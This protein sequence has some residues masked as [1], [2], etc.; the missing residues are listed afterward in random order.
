MRSIF[1]A[2][3]VLFAVLFACSNAPPPTNPCG[4]SGGTT[5]CPPGNGSG[6]QP[7]SN[8]AAPATVGPTATPT[9][10]PVGAWAPVLSYDNGSTPPASGS[11]VAGGGTYVTTPGATDPYTNIIYMLSDQA[12]LNG[13]GY[14]DCHQNSST[15]AYGI[16][17]GPN[18]RP[19]PGYYGVINGITIPAP[20]TRTGTSTGY[21]SQTAVPD[22][23]WF[24]YQS[25]PAYP[26]TCSGTAIGTYSTKSWSQT[27]DALALHQPGT[28]YNFVNRTCLQGS[29]GCNQGQLNGANTNDGPTIDI[30]LSVTATVWLCYAAGPLSTQGVNVGCPSA[31]PYPPG[32]PT[33]NPADWVWIDNSNPSM[34]CATGGKYSNYFEFT[35]DKTGM[36]S[37][38]YLDAR[39][40]LLN[41]LKGGTG[42]PILT[43]TNQG[44]SNTGNDVQ[45]NATYQLYQGANTAGSNQT[46]AIYEEAWQNGNKSA[47]GIT[48]TSGQWIPTLNAISQIAALH[49]QVVVEMIE[50]PNCITNNTSG[51][52]QGCDAA[53][54]GTNANDIIANN[55]NILN[56]YLDRMTI[57]ALGL[58]MEQDSFVS[59]AGFYAT[60]TPLPQNIVWEPRYN[61]VDTN[62]YMAWP[63]N[64][65]VIHGAASNGTTSFTDGNGA[66]NGSG[67]QVI[68][69]VPT[70]D[71]AGDAGGVVGLLV[72][73]PAPTTVSPV[74]GI[75]Q[76]SSAQNINQGVYARY[77]PDLCYNACATDIGNVL[78]VVNT[79]RS[80][81]YNPGGNYT[82]PCSTSF[83]YGN[84]AGGAATVVNTELFTSYILPSGGPVF[85]SSSPLPIYTWPATGISFATQ[86]FAC[87]SLTM[88]NGNNATTAG[89]TLA[90]GQGV[91]LN[92]LGI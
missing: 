31:S 12:A 84:A 73:N 65:L 18:H 74:C 71:P 72:T 39:N 7:G 26:G 61:G 55:P 43:F 63:E 49:R 90:P 16:Y 46:D 5:N 23:Y 15:C 38:G 57:T 89:G 86:L 30:N 69:G 80:S 25:V 22:A 34:L 56:F 36:S 3:A 62:V 79:M 42:V 83:T 19:D 13:R 68:H 88:I 20:T 48:L 9:S 27:T 75:S 32:G 33:P 82:I 4:N 54:G 51:S 76:N 1:V 92:T 60:N 14:T 85:Q 81:S 64:Q 47:P 70:V 40:G 10:T 2:I 29:T 6:G 44:C 77:I 66:D 67:C 59:S 35:G 91:M 58:L 28:G 11:G 78:V 17:L 24:W 21:C 53:H 87:G 52:A 8:G 37:T 41:I 45:P 50:D